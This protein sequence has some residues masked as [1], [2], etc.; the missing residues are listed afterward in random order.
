MEYLEVE[1]DI[2]KKTYRYHYQTNQKQM[3]FRYDNAAHHPHIPTHPDHRHADSGISE[4]HKP[5]IEE[6]ISEI[7][8]QYI[9]V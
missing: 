2:E 4:S 5:D 1:A 8:S 7:V 3:I 6:V 9:A